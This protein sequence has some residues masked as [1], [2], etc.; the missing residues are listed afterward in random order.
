[1]RSCGLEPA[2]RRIDLQPELFERLHPQHRIRASKDER[3]GRTHPPPDLDADGA[4]L[5]LPLAAIREP[6]GITP[7]KSHRAELTNHTGREDRV[8]GA[9][10]DEEAN[11]RAPAPRNASLD[12]HVTHGETL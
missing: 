9:G 4:R 12:E 7:R 11:G 2:L 10:V 1:M 6:D 3:D 5:E 8:R